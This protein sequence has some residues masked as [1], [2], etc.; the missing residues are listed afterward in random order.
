MTE[1]VKIENEELIVANKGAAMK[2]PN[3]ILNS[4]PNADHRINIHIKA[5]VFWWSGLTLFYLG[6]DL[7]IGVK[8]KVGCADKNKCGEATLDIFGFHFDGFTEQT[9]LAGLWILNLVFWVRLLWRIYISMQYNKF[10]DEAVEKSRQAKNPKAGTVEKIYEGKMGDFNKF[11]KW[12]FGLG[13][14]ILMGFVAIV[15][16]SHRLIFVCLQWPKMICC[17]ELDILIFCIV[18]AIL[19]CAMG[20]I[21]KI[22]LC[23]YCRETEKKCILCK[24]IK[25]LVYLV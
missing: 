13:I 9:F 3:N 8:N 25:Y 24:S 6:S 16:L 11:E 20:F 22:L 18:L 10:Y 7:K 23:E 1:N 4:A 5:L 14:P 12:L 21:F 19:L 17:I 15:C 2:R